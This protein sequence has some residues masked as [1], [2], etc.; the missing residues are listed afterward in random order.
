VQGVE[1]ARGS[2]Y[3]VTNYVWAVLKVRAL[4]SELTQALEVERHK[5]AL[6]STHHVNALWSKAQALFNGVDA[7]A[8][9]DDSHSGS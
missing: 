8:A 9:G 2:S 4:G 3:A 1:T 7:Q 6:M 5:T